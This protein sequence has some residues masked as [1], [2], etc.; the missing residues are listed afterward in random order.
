ME[1]GIV[2][3]QKVSNDF[4]DRHSNVNEKGKRNWVYALQPEGR[5]YR[6]RKWLSAAYLVLFFA[7]PFIKLNGMPAVE[8]NFPEARFILFG[9]IFWP[10]DFFIFAV[11]M[12]L[13]IVF[14]ALFTVI[15]GRVFCGWVCPQTVFM[16]F[17]F[18]RIEWWIEGS[19]SQQ[20][21]RNAAPL[22]RAVVFRKAVKHSI[23][24]LVSFLIA[25]TF[26]SYIIGVE[27]VWQ[28]VNAPV[29]E[30]LPLFAGLLFFTGLFYF[31]F[32][33]VRDI[34]CTTVCPYGRLQGVLF[35]KDTMQ[36]SYD[37]NR[38]EPRGK[39]NKKAAASGGD[40]VDCKLCVH[41]CPTGI[42]IRNGVQMECVGC[43]ACID[44]CNSVM[45]KIG[46][47]E[48]LIRM[49]S[50]HQISKKRPFRFNSR[51][52]FYTAALL[53]LTVIMAILVFS[54]KPIDTSI[55]RVKG[56]LYQE[57]GTD[58]LSNLFQ[59]KLINKTRKEVSFLFKVEGGMPG[60]VR[61]VDVQHPFLKPESLTHSTFFITL[62]AAAVKARST[63]IL[64]G[65]YVN[66]KR[67]STIKSKFLG[68]FI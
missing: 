4:R 11:A 45:L 31:V 63:T 1:T 50:E 64:I 17:V 47:Q 53:V 44:A 13:A 62:P 39:L 43:T 29:T 15:Y 28:L 16:E 8:L 68:P 27:K 25:H 66:G 14:I 59:A 40:C 19:P 65:V 6:C 33:F 54:R 7:L 60:S 22:G 51:M 20:R 55:S 30:N 41:V 36:V 18:R 58:S 2:G 10:D 3:P 35:D 49:A 34:V 26:L 42:D 52:R 9:K 48:G 24:L 67:I 61:M 5:L 57:V 56:Q 37:Y 21:K 12:I 38:G 23:F 32:A 46:R